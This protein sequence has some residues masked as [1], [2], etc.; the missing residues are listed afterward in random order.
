MRILGSVLPLFGLVLASFASAEAAVDAELIADGL[1]EPW[2]IAFLPDGDALITEKHGQLRYLRDGKL[3]EQTIKG[4][5]EITARGQ[6]G[7]MGIALHPNF[8][9]NKTLC[10]SY[11]GRDQAGASTEV[12]CGVLNDL[13]LIN[14]KTIF[15]AEPRSA[16][17]KHFGGRVLFDDDGRLFITLGD[18]GERLTAQQK[19]SHNGSLLRINL[20]G[21]VPADN[22]FTASANV[23]PEI[24]SFGHRNIQ[25]IAIHPLTG[26]IWT[27]EHGPQGGDEIN[28]TRAGKNYGWPVITYGVNYGFGTKIGEGVAKPGMEQPIHKWVPSIAPSGM[29]FYQG[30]RHSAWQGDLF[31]GSLKFGELVHLQ[32][33]GAKIVA[34]R[35]Y[36]NGKFGRIRDVAVDKNGYIYFLTE[37]HN[38][39][40][41]RL[42]TDAGK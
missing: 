5:P 37:A 28:I 10:L 42:I 12:M 29:V 41:M 40:L 11:V 19:N 32:L 4:L 31:V 22:P 15:V 21:S 8:I 25:G 39:Q 23:K 6:G 38:G 33:D 34:E 30:T 2:S 9:T 7:L 27:H 35:R 1:K 17:Q 3:L 24:Y 16:R 36:F 14:L 13:A 20:D 26:E 18:R